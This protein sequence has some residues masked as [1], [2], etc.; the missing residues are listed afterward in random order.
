MV[1][2]YNGY[3]QYG[4]GGLS[5]S[6]TSQISFVPELNLFYVMLSN[7]EELQ[8]H[9]EVSEIVNAV[10]ND[11]KLYRNEDSINEVVLDREIL[12]E[13]THEYYSKYYGAYFKFTIKDNQL[14]CNDVTPLTPVS[15]NSF[16]AYDNKTKF[17]FLRQKGGRPILYLDTP[18][19]SFKTTLINRYE[20][21]DLIR[22]TGTFYND[23]LDVYYTIKES[24]GH[25]ITEA[26][27]G[28][29]IKLFHFYGRDVYGDILFF[30]HLLYK[31]DFS[32]FYVSSAGTGDKY[33]RRMRDV[34]FVKVDL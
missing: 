17:I 24:D 9:N 31:K 27:N 22:F 16:V 20:N 28:E 5:S 3:K 7:S 14:Y 21:R 18:E 1:G 8:T 34:E 12:E 25:L 13:Y 19:Y 4:H 10:L 23:E 32:G 26:P 11:E 6:F 15:E 30:N 29:T 33:V 2:S